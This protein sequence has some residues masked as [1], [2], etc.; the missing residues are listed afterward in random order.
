MDGS[1]KSTV[2]TAL[3]DRLVRRGVE[4]ERA[5]ARL[6]AE[7]ILLDRVA[8]PVK[9]LLGRE[10]TIA[11]PV[12]AAGPSVAKVQD[13]RAATG[14]RGP[15]EWTWILIVAAVNARSLRAHAGRRRSGTA[16]VC[17]RWVPDALVD[18]ELRDGRHRAAEWLLRRLVPRPDL[19]LYLE[20]DPAMAAARKPGDKALATLERM[21]ELYERRA[22]TLRLTRLDANQPAQRVAAQAAVLVE[23]LL[24]DRGR[25]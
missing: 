4:V 10:G 21:Q 9:R 24:A 5:W 11:D 18:L 17:D 3:E 7:V 6:G 8:R 23:L 19:A 2:T 13:P 1:G 22:R 20:V 16:V 12:A 25:A 14:R 15:L